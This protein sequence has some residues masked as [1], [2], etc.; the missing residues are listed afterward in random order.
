MSDSEVDS[1][2][3]LADFEVDASSGEISV[4]SGAMI[5]YETKQSCT[6]TVFAQDGVTSIGGGLD[7]RPRHHHR[8][9]HR[10]L[11]FG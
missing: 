10:L 11:L 4:K 5:D 3:F 2:A 7:A 8:M 6:I 9:R 1:E